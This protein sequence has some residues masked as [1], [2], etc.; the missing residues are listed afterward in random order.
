[1]Y[2]HLFCNGVDATLFFLAL[3]AKSSW[4]KLKENN[5]ILEDID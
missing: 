1:M 5:G 2:V 4:P 3:P